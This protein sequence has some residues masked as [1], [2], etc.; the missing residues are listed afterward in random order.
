MVDILIVEDNKEL[1]G[2]LV[3]FL[4]AE[5]YVVS[6]AEDGNKALDLYEMYGARLL[7]L[8][9][10]LPG[11]DGMYILNKVREKSNT[12]VIMVSAK[13][14]KGDKLEAIISGADDYIEKPY[15]IDIL[16]A[17]IKGIFKRRLATDTISD[18]DITL[19]IVQEKILKDGV[20]LEATVKEFELMKLFMENKGHTL[21]KQYIFDTIWGMDSES[22][23]HT[24]AVHINRLR[25][26][27][28]ENPKKP[29]KIVTVWGKGY[30]YE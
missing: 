30:R 29:K 23:L 19:D 9:I 7:I 4:R 17:K 8:D 25:D 1:S 14:A 16:I 24:L 26:K 27:L 3:D 10:M 21:Q 22:D 12:P 28:E 20:A 6:A 13:V 11:L 18:E 5:G 2:M 15:D